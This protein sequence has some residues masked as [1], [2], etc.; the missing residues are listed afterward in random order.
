MTPSPAKPD[1]KTF[2]PEIVIGFV[3]PSGIGFDRVT[4][5]VRRELEH[6][7]YVSETA[8]LSSYLEELAPL[9]KKKARLPEARIPNLQT[10]G[11]YLRS[12]AGTDILGFVAAGLIRK[13]REQHNQS[14]APD[15]KDQQPREL[16]AVRLPRFA[17][18]G[19][20]HQQL[21]PPVQGSPH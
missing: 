4:E 12:A 18:S 1:A 7:D 5:V 8:R 13:A 14:H 10:T 2:Y 20:S 3:A 17:Q 11:D 15:P 6:H 19:G 9:S 16:S 21:G